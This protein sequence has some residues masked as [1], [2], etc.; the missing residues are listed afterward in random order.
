[1]DLTNYFKGKKITVMGLGLLGRGVGDAAF[2]AEQGAEV[3]VTDLKS[4]E[5]LK[6][7][8]DQLKEFDNIKFVLG[9]HRIDPTTFLLCLAREER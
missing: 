6:D 8:V 9:E 7:S 2:L 5:D 3:I 4:A 1:M